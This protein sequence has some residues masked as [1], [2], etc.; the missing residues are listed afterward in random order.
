MSLN[1]T[2]RQLSIA[3]ARPWLIVVIIIVITTT[4]PPEFM[5]QTFGD[6]LTLAVALLGAGGAVMSRANRGRQGTRNE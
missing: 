3:D 2:P 1:S 6:V 5:H 4:V